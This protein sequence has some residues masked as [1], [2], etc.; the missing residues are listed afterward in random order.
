MPLKKIFNKFIVL[1]LEGGLGN[2]LFQYAFAKAVQK[3]YGG[4]ILFDLYAI[5]K[6]NQRDI[7]LHHLNLKESQIKTNTPQKLVIYYSRFKYFFIVGGISR[8]F[9]GN[10][11]KRKFLSLVG[12]FKQNSTLFENYLFKSFSPFKYISGNWMSENYFTLEREFIKKELKV[13]TKSSSNNKKMI[14]QLNLENSVC[15]HIRRGDYTNSNWA[16]QL[17]VCNFNYYNKAISY[18]NKKVDNPIFYVFSNSN[19]DIKWIK[20]NY[21]FNTNVNYVEL[22]NPDYEE[23][24]LMYNCKHFI[25]SNSSF[26]WWASYL[27]ENINKIIVAP[28]KWNTGIYNME[29]VYLESWHIINIDNE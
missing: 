2:Q 24:R 25:L 15:V 21:K 29:A 5:K 1:R 3:K 19:E 28:S 9:R 14:S 18:L 13:L 20:E 26:S 12:V 8:W 6:D 27:S 22:N 17:L 16:K 11:K 10:L 4:Q 7:S 23:L